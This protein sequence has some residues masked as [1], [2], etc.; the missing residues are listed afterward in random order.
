MELLR[1]RVGAALREPMSPYFTPVQGALGVTALFSIVAF[2]FEHF[3]PEFYPKV[4]FFVQWATT[5]IFTVEYLLRIWVAEYKLSYIASGWGILDLVSI[6]PTYLG[7]GD[8]TF[9]KAARIIRTFRVLRLVSAAH[10]LKY[11]RR[12]G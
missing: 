7:L 6:L 3:A 2:G 11:L 8:F 12:E 10:N 5:I 4:F 9:L 1:H